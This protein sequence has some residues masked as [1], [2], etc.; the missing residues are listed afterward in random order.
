MRN[1]DGVI[2]KITTFNDTE[3]PGEILFA[4]LWPIA[5]IGIG[6]VGC[7]IRLLPFGLGFGTLAYDPRPTTA[8][9]AKALKQ[10][11]IKKSAK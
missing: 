5:G 6:P 11:K 8:Q 9:A 7:R 1:Y 10:K 2:L 3:R 4:D